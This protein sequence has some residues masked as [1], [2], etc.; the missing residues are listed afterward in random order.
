LQIIFFANFKFILEI[1]DPQLALKSLQYTL[2]M[3]Q[4]RG[5]FFFTFAPEYP[6]FTLLGRLQMEDLVSCLVENQ[7]KLSIFMIQSVLMNTI[8]GSAS[9]GGKNTENHAKAVISWIRD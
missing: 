4:C 6:K 2:D 9:N 3:A 1:R 8:L 7:V 5:D